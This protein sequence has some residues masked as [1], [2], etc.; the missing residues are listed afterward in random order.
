MPC[1]DLTGP[2]Q[3]GRTTL[4]RSVFPDAEYVDLEDPEIHVMA[5]YDMREFP[6]R[7]PAPVVFDEVQYVPELFRYV[8]EFG[9]MGRCRRRSVC[10]VAHLRRWQPSR[11]WLDGDLL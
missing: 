1:A 2:R 11:L 5:L 4:A 7:H 6:R 9:E 10:H 3:S 8:P